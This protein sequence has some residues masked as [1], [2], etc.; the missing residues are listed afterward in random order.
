V[1][2]GLWAGVQYEK[3]TGRVG[4]TVVIASL[5]TAPLLRVSGELDHFGGSELCAVGREVLGANGRV[6]LL[7][8]SECTYIDS[9]GLGTLF[10][11][12]RD[13]GPDGVL[14]LI[15]VNQ[16]VCRILDIVGLPRLAS[17]RLFADAA[18]A[19]DFLVV[20]YLEAGSPGSIE[21]STGARRQ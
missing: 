17:L 16:D 19:S 4:V 2:R 8:L 13:L 5:G 3:P 20:E 18:E 1:R 21:P 11:L 14:G 6:L 7:E 15:G 12:L 9:G 10:G